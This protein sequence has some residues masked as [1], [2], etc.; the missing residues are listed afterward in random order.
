MRRPNSWRRL[1]I[2]GLSVPILALNIWILGQLLLYFEQLFTVLT[3]AAVLALL[4][5][6]LVQGLERLGLKRG[7]AILCV[8][9]LTLA[10]LVLLG[11]VLVPLVIQQATQ[12]LE[13]LPTWLETGNQNLNWLGRFAEQRRIPL[14]LE[15]IS[16]QI[17]DQIRGLVGSLPGV[18]I[19]TLGRLLDT[20]LILVLAFYML[21]YG[22]RLWQGLINLLPVPL[23]PILSHSLQLNFQR[24]FIVQLLLACFM[25][26]AMLPV[27]LALQI[28]FG[29]LFALVIGVAQLIPVI[30]ATVGIGIVTLLVM[31]QNLWLAVQVAIAAVI[32]QQI[33]D[34]VLSPKLLGDVIGL[35]PLWQFI[36][37]LIGARVAGLLGAIL[38]IPIAGTIKATF[39]EMREFYQSLAELP[40]LPPSS[41]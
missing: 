16:N 41:K 18:A 24:F 38:S 36:A 21:F 22:G 12:L 4:L 25:V 2:L 6:Y 40:R 14:K 13:G 35:N 8:L 30:G 3:L 5:N 37:L 9:L 23:G 1:L 19:G 34:N 15:Q 27:V 7:Q 26:L 32:L 20:I 39:E 28:N 11:F 29:L 10:I 31:L 17:A 33:K